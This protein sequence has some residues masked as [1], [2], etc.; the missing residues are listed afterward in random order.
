[1]PIL[2]QKYHSR[3]AVSNSIFILQPNRQN[4]LF[5]QENKSIT[6]KTITKFIGA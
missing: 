4:V 6:K 1:M 3:Q 2:W 5:A